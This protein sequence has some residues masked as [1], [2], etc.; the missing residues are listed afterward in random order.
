MKK[1]FFSKYLFVLLL[2]ITARAA[3]LAQ[4]FNVIDI[5]K[6]KT[7]NPQNNQNSSMN[8]FAEV[9]GVFYFSADDGIHGT[10]L[11]RSDA[12]NKGTEMVK[13]INPGTASSDPANIFA[14]GNK[15]Y[16][17]AFD[18]KHTQQLWVS[19]GTTAGTKPL[20]DLVVAAP[21]IFTGS[22]SLTDVDGTL[23]FINNYYNFNTDPYSYTQLW[24]SDGTEEGTEM[25]VD[26][27]AKFNIN[28]SRDLVNVNGRL[29]FVLYG[30]PETGT[31]L[32]TSD[33]TAEGTILIHL[34]IVIPPI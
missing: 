1:I 20:V 15:L 7:S 18:D 6:I 27:G 16:F 3:L 33:G 26:L 13:D 8:M 2:S 25:V 9:N 32:Y 10:E 23:Y 21:N 14:S 11:W 12:T 22:T 34:A 19:D 29:F 28:I 4:D 30:N 5:N 31:E 17:T 24:K